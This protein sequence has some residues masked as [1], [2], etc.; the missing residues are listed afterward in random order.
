MGLR[1]L[2]VQAPSVEGRHSEIV[3]PL[4]LA[5]VAAA[6]RR[7]GHD[8]D[9]LDLNLHV[10]PLPALT[11]AI[12]RSAPQI[13]GLGLR[14]IDPLANRRHSYLPMFAAV[15]ETIRR[16][17]P[18][19]PVVVGGPGFSMFPAEIMARYPALDIGVVLE[20]ETTFPEVLRRLEDA[21]PRRGR[22]APVEA[23]GLPGTLVRAEGDPGVVVAGPRRRRLRQASLDDVRTWLPELALDYG[24]STTYAP[25]VG[26]ET[27]RGC[28]L[29]C[30][31]CVYPALQG[32]RTR[33]RS[34][35]T[36][37]AEVELLHREAG[38]GWVHFTDPVL[39][40]PP[41]HFRE[42]C[43][44]L[45]E[46]RLPVQ[47]TG[48][49]REDVLTRADAQLAVRAGCAA[50]Q[51][52]GDGTC[53]ATLARLHKGLTRAD[54]LSAAAHAAQTEALSVYHFMVNVP[55]TDDGVASG[56]AEL[57][58][59]LHDLHEPHANLGAI[60]L[61]NLRVYPRTRLSRELVRDGVLEP[62]ED[63]LYP[64]YHDPPP[65]QHLRY[66]LEERHQ[67]RDCGRRAVLTAPADRVAATPAGA[68]AL[69]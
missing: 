18:D 62:G 37:V 56:A 16:A 25:A 55:G 6:A 1:V 63:L 3:A 23:A 26:I 36:I 35:D 44:R 69:P 53:D 42:V 27:K 28:P 34:P 33:F 15:L 22:R 30:S 65:F 7:G 11:D 5:V 31:Y 66:E 49:F 54:I 4:G 58:D 14:N 61:N 24:G 50:F 41:G 40:S 46:R 9:L 29:S 20:G 47:W 12:A 52:S 48:F 45:I 67:L 51:F 59:R 10:D 57:I 64:T 39:N 2:L 21:A 38:V 13:V 60:V 17:L 68:G 43:S 8:V 19:A 32:C